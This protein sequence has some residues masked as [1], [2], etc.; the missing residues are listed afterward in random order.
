MM[1]SLDNI[2]AFY[3]KSHILHGVSLDVGR[4][5]IVSLLGRNGAG[6]TTT[7]KSIV[8]IV[9]P[10]EGHIH[11]E[12]SPIEGRPTHEIA[13]LGIAL[14]PE[15][16]GIFATLSVQENLAVALRPGS[17]WGIEDVFTHFPRLRERRNSRGGNL[18]GGEQQMLAIARALVNAP[19]LLLLDEPTEGL[20]PVIV[21]ELIGIIAGI[22]A[23]GI[24]ILLVEQ[25]LGVC[26]ELADRHYVLEQG[27]IVYSGTREEFRGAEAVRERYLTLQAAGH[28]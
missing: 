18:S 27:R 6:K 19:K 25:N 12:G 15:H 7:L 8:G 4:G 22:R 28:G 17:A 20:A 24:P 21:D 3:G 9:P 2:H 14:V 13:R 11:F 1:L 26:M 5:E 16:R 23:H 10:R